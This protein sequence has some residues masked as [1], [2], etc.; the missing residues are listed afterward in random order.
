MAQFCLWTSGLVDKYTKVNAESVGLTSRIRRFLV[1]WSSLS[2]KLLRQL[3]QLKPTSAGSTSS[4][5]TS[6]SSASSFHILQLLLHEYIL[7]EIEH[8]VCEDSFRELMFNMVNAQ[9]PE[10]SD[11]S[12]I[13]SFGQDFLSNPNLFHGH[14]E[15]TGEAAAVVATDAATSVSSATKG[16]SL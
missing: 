9:A 12:F 15:H 10:L 6:S 1:I 14:Y 4:T 7:H 13:D 8:L 16:Q 5:S 2:T 3:K 11:S